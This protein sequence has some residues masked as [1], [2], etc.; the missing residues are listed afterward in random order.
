MDKHLNQHKYHIE[1]EELFHWFY[2]I[3]FHGL[4]GIL[5]I[6]TTESK[7]NKRSIQNNYLSEDDFL[8][9]S[10]PAPVNCNIIRVFGIFLCIDD[11]VQGSWENGVLSFKLI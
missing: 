3:E 5:I 10:Q 9:W 2:L 6:P 7:L 11:F 8:F 4:N 1:D